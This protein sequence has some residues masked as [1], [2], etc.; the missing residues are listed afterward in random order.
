VELQELE[1]AALTGR[2]EVRQSLLA[3][4]MAGQQVDLA[5]TNRLPVIGARMAFEA[6]R[7]TFA[8]QVGANWMFAASL[9]W[10]LF[11]GNQTHEK[12]RE[13]TAQMQGAE[14][15]RRRAEQGVKLEVRAAHAALREAES[16]LPSADATVRMAEESL[17][18]TRNRY[19]AGLATL[20]DLLRV[21][22]AAQEAR[23]RRL[24]A[25]HDQRLAAVLL[26]QALG[27][28]NGDSDVLN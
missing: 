15:D 1:S 2:A 20:S 14:A 13:A 16:R 18:I 19:E 22:T 23:F 9:K 12:I 7:G 26:E 4:Q 3:K 11:D 28:L 25:I 6:D 21:E 10:N 8:T 17:R 24:A 27:R 5:R